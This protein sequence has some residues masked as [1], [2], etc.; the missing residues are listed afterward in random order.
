M[1]PTMGCTTSASNKKVAVSDQFRAETWI[2]RAPLAMPPGSILVKGHGPATQEARAFRNS[3]P[4][5]ASMDAEAIV[6]FH[7]LSGE[8]GS[9]PLQGTLP[10]FTTWNIC[11][12]LPTLTAVVAFM[13][14]L[15]RTCAT[16]TSGRL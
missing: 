6:A 8:Q 11:T 9:R 10:V 5:P 2:L 13:E 16:T 1:S 3:F 12:A 15:A 14:Y 4:S 7:F